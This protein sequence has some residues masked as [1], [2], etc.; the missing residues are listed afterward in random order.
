MQSV[1]PRDP[2]INLNR[3]TDIPSPAPACELRVVPRAIPPGLD[4]ERAEALCQ[5]YR[6]L[7]MSGAIPHQYSEGIL[8]ALGGV[9]IAREQRHARS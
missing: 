2:R 7:L 4:P 3:R 6:L 1:K 5:Q 8:S 9:L